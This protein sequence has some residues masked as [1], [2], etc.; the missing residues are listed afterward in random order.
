M[1][2]VLPRAMWGHFSSLA[3][4]G[5][6]GILTAQTD[7]PAEAIPRIETGMHGAAITRIGVERQ[8]ATELAKASRR[9]VIDLVLERSR[10]PDL[11]RY[12]KCGAASMGRRGHSILIRAQLST[13]S[14]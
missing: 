4:V 1:E 2:H 6:R 12:Y 7:V 9:S 5:I 11:R 13:R 8:A 14:G 3:G 10:R